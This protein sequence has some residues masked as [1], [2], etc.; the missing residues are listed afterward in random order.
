MVPRVRDLSVEC[1][2]RTCLVEWPSEGKDADL[3][4]RMAAQIWRL[5]RESESRPISTTSG[6]AG[7]ALFFGSDPG[8][9]EY[10]ASDAGAFAGR[11]SERRERTIRE[12]QDGTRKLPAPL[13]G[14]S[15]P[16]VREEGR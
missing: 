2:T 13:Q 11:L 8:D 16:A 5:T 3:K 1:R 12:F 14:S 15:L 6:R 10:D 7:V 4:I 9:Q